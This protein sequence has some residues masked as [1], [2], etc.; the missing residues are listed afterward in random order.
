MDHYSDLHDLG[1]AMEEASMILLTYLFLR[2]CRK[3]RLRQSLVRNP[4]GENDDGCND[5]APGDDPIYC[6]GLAPDVPMTSVY[7][8][9]MPFI[10]ADTANVLLIVFFPSVALFLPNLMG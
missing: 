6:Q 10:W 1:T 8:G 9:V 2:P 5:I 3:S 4:C 7:K